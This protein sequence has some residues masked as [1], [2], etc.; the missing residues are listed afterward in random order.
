MRNYGRDLSGPTQCKERLIVVETWPTLAAHLT[1]CSHGETTWTHT[2]QEPTQQ[3][4]LLSV[5]TECGIDPVH[6][7]PFLPQRTLDVTP[8]ISRRASHSP[9]TQWWIGVCCWV[10]VRC[11]AIERQKGVLLPVGL[12][13]DMFIRSLAALQGLL[14]VRTPAGW[15]GPVSSP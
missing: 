9:L 10:W 13:G 2:H 4:S 5:W 6:R 11:S 15:Q 7:F 8:L 1:A 3:P 12:C 14:R